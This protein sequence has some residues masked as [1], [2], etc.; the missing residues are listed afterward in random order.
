MNDQPLRAPL[1]PGPWSWSAGCLPPPPVV[2]VWFPPVWLCIA[3][4]VIT[5]PHISFHVIAFRCKSF[6]VIAS[7]CI[8]LHVIALHC[9]E[10]HCIASHR[11]D[12]CT[13]M[14]IHI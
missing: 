5:Y 1:P 2:V 6:H 4:H 10:L 3:L 8:A 11:I 12:A 14:C 13:R 7:D 9:I